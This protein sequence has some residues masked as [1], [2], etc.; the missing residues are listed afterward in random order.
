MRHG[1]SKALKS[2]CR[3]LE[4]RTVHL[5]SE[6]LWYMKTWNTNLLFIA[7]VD[8][9]KCDKNVLLCS[10]HRE[11]QLSIFRIGICVERVTI[12][13]NTCREDAEKRL[14]EPSNLLA[15]GRGS[16]LSIADPAPCPVNHVAMGNRERS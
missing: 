6:E 8:K 11:Y 15:Q 5:T 2:R 14:S 12:A 3:G 9:R 10:S 16:A 7:S 4:P 1:E 13:S